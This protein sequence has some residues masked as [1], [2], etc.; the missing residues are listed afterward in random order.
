MLRRRL[1][2][3]IDDAGAAPV[4]DAYRE[5]W[6]ANRDALAPEAVKAETAAGVPERLSTPF[7]RTGHLHDQ[8]GNAGELSVR[9]RYVAESGTYRGDDSATGNRDNPTFMID[10]ILDGQC[11]N[12][13][14]THTPEAP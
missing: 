1:F 9:S 3:R 7:G 4:I 6:N 5:L 11:T 13:Q 12:S 10:Q 8:D 14:C 2:Q